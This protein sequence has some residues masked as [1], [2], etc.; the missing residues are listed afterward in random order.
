MKIKLKIFDHH[1]KLSTVRHK[2]TLWRLCIHIHCLLQV[3]VVPYSPVNNQ[4]QGLL[5][6]VKRSKLVMF[7][8]NVSI[9][10]GVNMMTEAF[11]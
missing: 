9:I 8:L 5:V 1:P 7:Q 10:L 11:S 4:K 3:A 6:P 2:V